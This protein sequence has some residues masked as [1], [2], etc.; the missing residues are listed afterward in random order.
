MLIRFVS[1][2]HGGF[3]RRLY[4]KDDTTVA[5]LFE[6][7]MEDADPRDYEISIRRD[8]HRMDYLTEDEPLRENDLVIIRPNKVVGGSR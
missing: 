5:D 8:G 4:V 7:E 1:H 2:D 3:A 6:Q